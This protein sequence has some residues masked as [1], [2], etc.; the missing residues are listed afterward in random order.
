MPSREPVPRDSAWHPGGA[1]RGAGR[2]QRGLEDAGPW[3]KEGKRKA[4]WTGR[5]LPAF[6]PPHAQPTRR[7]G[8]EGPWTAP[9]KALPLP[10][11]Q[12]HGTPTL[13]ACVLDPTASERPLVASQPSPKAKDREINQ[14]ARGFLGPLEVKLREASIY[15][16]CHLK[17]GPSK[18]LDLKPYMGKFSI[19]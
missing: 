19:N 16:L 15:R 1:S 8:D 10:H 18:G 6:L 9:H 4:A 14:A 5:G 12:F 3:A 13:H 7:A 17:M 2:P 11:T